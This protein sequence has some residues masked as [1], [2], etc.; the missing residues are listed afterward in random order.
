MTLSSKREAERLHGMSR[1]AP[2]SDSKSGASPRS[3]RPSGRFYRPELDALRFLAFLSVFFCH[4]LPF[5][6]PK[7]AHKGHIWHYFQY[8]RESGNFGVCLFFL[9]SSYLIT[10]LLRREYL[11]TGSVHL[12]AFYLRR[13]LRIWPLYFATLAMVAGIGIVVPAL[14]MGGMQFLAFLLFVGNWHMIA[15]SLA[16]PLSWLWSISVEEQFY[17][18]WPTMAKVGGTRAI[19]VGSILCLPLALVAAVYAVRFQSNP[20]VSVW[21]NSVVQF[22]FFAWGALLTAF[23]SGKMLDLSKSLR[24]STAVTGCICW[25]LASGVCHIKT[26]GSHP[27]AFRICVGYELVAA[28]CICFLLAALGASVTGVPKIFI[29]LGKISYGLYIFHGFA[30]AATTGLRQHFERA[31][32]PNTGMTWLLFFIDRVVSLAITIGLSVLSYEYFESPFLKLKDRFSF[33]Q[34]RPV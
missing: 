15:S 21:L 26:P 6:D 13:S 29:Y 14:H 8:V 31:M 16:N 10:E 12:Q 11:S 28:G 25:L 22:Q 3:G 1:S 30:L 24:I 27:S 32:S 2:D 19:T 9:L 17:V 20:D 7:H 23:L 33:V 18:I 5:D 34:S 4:A